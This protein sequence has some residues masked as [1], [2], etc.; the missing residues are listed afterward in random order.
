M[1][2]DFPFHSL[3]ILLVDNLC[4]DSEEM[5]TTCMPVRNNNGA[6]ETPCELGTKK[7]LF[8]SVMKS[9][10]VHGTYMVS[11]YICMP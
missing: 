8:E 9:T 4:V 1:D 11:L 3:N 7:P 6:L 10:Y 5:G 2:Y